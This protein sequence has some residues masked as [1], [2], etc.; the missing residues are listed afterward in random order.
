MEFLATLFS[1]CLNK[2]GDLIHYIYQKFATILQ[3]R[4]SNATGMPK[5][6]PDGTF[7][8]FLTPSQDPRISA[9]LLENEPS[10]WFQVFSGTFY[11]IVHISKYFY[12]G[13]ID[14]YYSYYVDTYSNMYFLPDW[15]SEFLQ[16]NCNIY[17]DTTVL[18][19]IQDGI[20]LALLVCFQVIS[21]RISL[22][23][24]VIINPYVRPWVYLTSL[25]DWT[26]DLTA[27]LTPGVWGIDVGFVFFMTILGKFTDC[28]NFIVFTMPYLPS[29]GQR[30]VLDS[31]F[32]GEYLDLTDYDFFLDDKTKEVIFFRYF[33][34]L[35][36]EYGVPNELREYWFNDRP[37]I[38]NYMI[39]YYD[40]LGLNFYPDGYQEDP[41]QKI[42][43]VMMLDS[44]IF[45]NKV[46]YFIDLIF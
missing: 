42:S 41:I 24:F 14:G 31:N 33:P 43:S 18:E 17:L 15:A 32:K 46:S 39:K 20:L 9:G 16:I 23:W 19:E 44:N 26:Y 35:W 2:A 27:G 10:S 36:Y 4:F 25:V 6:I 12:Q 11:D 13:D 34:Q 21:L 29:E 1:F 28:V 40:Y 3:L 7:P 45:I 8:S 37:D 30:G 38:L 5:I 22:Y